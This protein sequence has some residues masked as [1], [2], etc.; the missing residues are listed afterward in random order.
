[1]DH[2]H[3]NHVKWPSYCFPAYSALSKRS[4]AI[5]PGG[6]LAGAAKRGL[7]HSA[8][9]LAWRLARM[10]RVKLLP[11]LLAQGRAIASSCTLIALSLARASGETASDE[12]LASIRVH[13]LRAINASVPQL[14]G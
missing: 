7:V 5:V 14:S 12:T 11:L 1:M 13:Q 8:L 3:V 10:D 4:R 9:A 2:W 6:P